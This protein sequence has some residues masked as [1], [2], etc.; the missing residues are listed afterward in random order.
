L[1]VRK[2]RKR[3]YLKRQRRFPEFSLH[4]LRGAKKVYASKNVRWLSARRW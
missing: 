2:L 1:Q 3:R 4:E